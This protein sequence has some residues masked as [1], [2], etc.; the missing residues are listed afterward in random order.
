MVLWIEQNVPAVLLGAGLGS[1]IADHLFAARFA[2][3]LGAFAGVGIALP[4]WQMYQKHR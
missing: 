1:L 2:W 3:I 4:L